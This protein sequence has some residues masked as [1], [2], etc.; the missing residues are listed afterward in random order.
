LLELIL[1]ASV[2]APEKLGVVNILVCGDRLV[3]V[4]RDR[5]EISS[6][7]DV[8]IVDVEGMTVFPGLIDCHAHITGGGGE[9]GYGSRIPPIPVSSFAKSGVTSVVGLLGTDDLTQ[10]TGSVVTGCYGLRSAGLSAWCFTGG[11]HYPPTTLTGSVRSDIVYVDPVIGFGE[12]AISDHRSSQVSLDELL[13]VA[14]ECHVAGVMT[15]KAGIAHLHLGDGER[16]LQ[17]VREAIVT[18]EIPARVFNPTHVNRRR[19]LFEEACNLASGGSTIDVTA[20]PVEDG[21][22]AWTAA[23]A[24]ERYLRAGYPSGNITVSSDGGGCLPVFDD[25]GVIERM[26]VASAESLLVE[27]RSLMDCDLEIEDWLPAFTSNVASILRLDKKG[28]IRAGFDAD[29]VVLDESGGAFDVMARGRW[30]LRRGETL[31]H[32]MLE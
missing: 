28:Q 8:S 9:A 26:S 1:N 7:V 31:I 21:E 20:F 3:Y 10:G 25:E 23:E 32:G 12:L 22:D 5:P 30:H 29:L 6:A 24:V 14:S 11:Y 18:S 4:G 19:G 13:R 16:G 15:G 17:L 2:Y 27:A